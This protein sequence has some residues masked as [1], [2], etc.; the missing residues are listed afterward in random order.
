MEGAEGGGEYEGGREGWRERVVR[1][2]VGASGQISRA[3]QRVVGGWVGGCVGWVERT[4][5]TD[6]WKD[7]I[8]MGGGGEETKQTGPGKK[9][10]TNRRHV[11]AGP[12]GGSCVH[13]SFF[14]QT[15]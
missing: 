1:G 10:W 9:A 14:L 2:L 13:E 11:E 6:R 5:Q 7:G 4:E 3:E 8:I 15:F 12:G